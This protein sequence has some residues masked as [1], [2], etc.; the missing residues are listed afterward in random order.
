MG[1]CE[2]AIMKRL[3]PIL[4]LVLVTLGLTFAQNPDASAQQEQQPNSARA[5][6]GAVSAQLV[7]G[8]DAKKLKA[9]D[10]VMAR[11]TQEMRASDGTLVPVGSVVKGH[12]VAA[13]A[14]AKGDPQSSISIAFDNIVL[15]NGQQLPLQATIQAVG[16]PPMMTPDQ[17]GAAGSQPTMT[18]P[19]SPSPPGTLSPTGPM[20]GGTPLSGQPQPGGNFPQDAGNQGHTPDL[21]GLTTQSTGVIGLRNIELQP[22]STLTSTAK[23]LKLDSG[24]ELIL[25]VQSR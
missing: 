19:G 9:G 3:L 14:K 20:G 6:G 2:G 8:L 5:G 21:G 11:V 24:T 1:I 18:N 7:K 16:A 13:T 23:D 25:R 22:N 15:K 10:P 17:Y 4:A 12:V